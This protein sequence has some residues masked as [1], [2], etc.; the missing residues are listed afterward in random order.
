MER[1]QLDL[2]FL[3]SVDRLLA[4]SASPELERARVKLAAIRTKLL[5]VVGGETQLASDTLPRGL[6]P[7]FFRDNP[8][9]LSTLAGE[10]L[11]ETLNFVFEMCAYYSEI[12]AQRPLTPEENQLGAELMTCLN[13]AQAILEEEKR[14]A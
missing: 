9:L 12:K 1:N 3:E 10:M 4:A 13:T 7:A 14:K 6:L 5:Q 8:G 11:Q 2:A